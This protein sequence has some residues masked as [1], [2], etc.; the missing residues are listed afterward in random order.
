MQNGPFDTCF[1]RHAHL[2]LSLSSHR[3]WLTARK[4]KVDCKGKGM[5]S[6]Y[7]CNPNATSGAGTVA[8]FSEASTNDDSVA[9]KPQYDT[10]V[11]ATDAKLQRL[12]DWN[13]DMFQGLL[14]Q[15]VACQTSSTPKNRSP[16]M[17]PGAKV[18][19]TTPLGEVREV[20]TLPTTSRSTDNA[21]KAIQIPSIA[22]SQLRELILSIA[23]LYKPNPFHNFDHVR[24]TSRC[25]THGLSLPVLT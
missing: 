18:E 17:L 24:R 22:L 13:F 3:H 10:E 16:S 1:R 20:L 14:T 15:V 11:P 8:T 19:S 7:W 25:C 21:R 2:S 4:E 9:V 12:V 6:T 5:M 23:L